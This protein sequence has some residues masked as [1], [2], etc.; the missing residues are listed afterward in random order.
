MID[1]GLSFFSSNKN[2]S[3]YVICSMS[4]KLSGEHLFDEHTGNQFRADL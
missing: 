1:G 3:A 4:S 2:I